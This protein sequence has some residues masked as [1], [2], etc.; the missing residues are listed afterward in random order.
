M[1]DY[2]KNRSKNTIITEANG[3]YNLCLYRETQ[4]IYFSA[5]LQDILDF[6]MNKTNEEMIKIYKELK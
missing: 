2:N 5:S 4:V 1:F 3:V 6:A